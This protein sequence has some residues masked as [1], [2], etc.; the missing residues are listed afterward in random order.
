LWPR[1]EN[2]IF[3]QGQLYHSLIKLQNKSEVSKDTVKIGGQG[4]THLSF[5]QKCS[6]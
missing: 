4:D 6:R 2:A 5:T 1:V 3:Q